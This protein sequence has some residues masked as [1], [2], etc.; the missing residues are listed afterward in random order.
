MAMPK[1]NNDHFSTKSTK[2][3]KQEFIRLNSPQESIDLTKIMRILSISR[4]QGPIPAPSRMKNI[5]QAEFQ[6]TPAITHS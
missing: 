1:A 6:T 3:S 4:L 2:I 5:Q